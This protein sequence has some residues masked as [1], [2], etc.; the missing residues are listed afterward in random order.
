MRAHIVL[1][2]PGGVGSVQSSRDFSEWITRAW[3]LQEAILGREVFCILSSPKSDKRDVDLKTV[4]Q[5]YSSKNFQRVKGNKGISLLLLTDWLDLRA[6]NHDDPQRIRYLSMV[7]LLINRNAGNPETRD[8]AIWRNMYYRTS[9]KEQDRIFSIMNLFKCPITVDYTRTFD[10]LFFE[11]A[12]KCL[13]KCPTLLSLLPY[14]IDDY[15][16][17]HPRSGI[18]LDFGNYFQSEETGKSLY[19]LF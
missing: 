10:D 3:T 19:R 2:M 16:K 8:C 17:P 12:N 1:V 15:G 14:G 13:A 4:P 18:I 11:L 5:D 9:S 6:H 7:D